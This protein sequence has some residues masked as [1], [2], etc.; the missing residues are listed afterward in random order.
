MHNN[1]VNQVCKELVRWRMR[2]CSTH[3]EWPVVIKAMI[4]YV[5]RQQNHQT[6]RDT[7]ATEWDIKAVKQH[8]SSSAN[9]DISRICKW[10]TVRKVANS[11]Q[12]E[13]VH[14]TTAHIIEQTKTAS[15]GGKTRFIRGY[16]G[17]IH[18]AKFYKQDQ[19]NEQLQKSAVSYVRYSA[20][21]SGQSEQS[22]VE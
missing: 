13:L 6:G 5:Q 16:T 12:K 7:Y 4:A 9:A 18:I 14:T 2:G 22:Q 21:T 20:A 15:T 1:S 17:S 10:R 11:T 8:I 19:K 3:S